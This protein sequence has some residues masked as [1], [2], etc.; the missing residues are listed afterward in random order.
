MSNTHRSTPRNSWPQLLCLLI[1]SLWP[2]E[3]RRPRCWRCRVERR[4]RTRRTTEERKKR[5]KRHEGVPCPAD[6]PRCHMIAILGST[7]ASLGYVFFAELS[8]KFQSRSSLQLHLR[9]VSQRRR[10][11][12]L[13][14]SWSVCARL[15]QQTQ[16]R[17]L[18]LKFHL[19]LQLFTPL[20]N[21]INNHG[22][23][24]LLLPSLQHLFLT[25]DY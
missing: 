11:R 3:E 7:L 6:C 14:P 18:A 5:A 19:Q 16:P 24:T 1:S 4:W 21:L 20:R 23:S 12:L 17:C 13:I 22:N 2:T 10:S 15:G 8:L 25:L 9:R